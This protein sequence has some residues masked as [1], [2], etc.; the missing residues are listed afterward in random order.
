[1]KNTRTYVCCALLFV[2]YYIQGADRHRHRHTPTRVRLCV[3][4]LVFLP[5][6]VVQ[7]NR[8]HASCTIM[9]TTRICPC[10]PFRQQERVGTRHQGGQASRIAGCCRCCIMLPHACWLLNTNKHRHRHRHNRNRNQQ[11]L[12]PPH[13]PPAIRGMKDLGSGVVMILPQVHLQGYRKKERK[14]EKDGGNYG[15]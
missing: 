10:C 6:F 4:V 14:K 11:R 9:Y 12:A 1:M 5:L 13:V 15:E 7:E 2:F 3:C 8:T